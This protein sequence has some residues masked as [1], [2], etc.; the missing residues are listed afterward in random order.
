MIASPWRQR[1][2]VV[3]AVVTAVLLAAAGVAGYVRDELVDRDNFSAR[4]AAALDDAD[5]RAVVADK[6]VDGVAA[7]VTPDVLAIRPLVTTAIASLANTAQFKRIFRRAIADQHR[8]LFYGRSRAV[9]DLEYAGGLLQESLRSVSPLVAR[10]IPPGTEPQ[11]A[12]LDADDLR[13]TIARKLTNVSGWWLPLLIAAALASIAC[14]VLAGGVRDGIAYLGAAIAAAGLTVA[15][16]TMVAAAWVVGRVS[17]GE[18]ERRAAVRAIWDALFADLR[19]SALVAALGGLVIAGVASRRPVVLFAHLRRLSGAPARAPRAL[20]GA[21]LLALGAAVVL[22]PSLAVRAVSVLA[23]LLLILLG[24]GELRGRANK[25]QEREREATPVRPLILV[26]IVAGVVTAMV[27]AVALV[28]PAPKVEAPPALAALAGP[29]GSCNGSL[30]NCGKRLN[31]VVFPST[32]NSYAAADEPGWLFPNQRYGIERQLRDGI[33]GLLIDV[34][35]GELDPATGL[36]RTDLDA[37]GSDRNKV[38]KQLS[39]QALRAAERLVGRIGV[40]TGSGNPRPYLCHTLCELGS[41]PLD[42]QFEI[43]RRFLDANRGE[44]VILFVE[45]YVPVQVIEDSLQRTGLLSEAAEL[46]RDEPLP[47]LGELV[48]ANTRLVVLSELDGGSRPWYLDGFSFVQDTPL[49]ATNPDNLSC[50]RWRGTADSPLLMLNHWTVNFPPSPSRNRAI[51]GPVLRDQMNRCERERGQLPNLVAVDFYELTG[52]LRLAHQR[53][54][55]A[56]TP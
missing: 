34:H 12:A 18:E 15:L 48:D 6:V 11:L 49:T 4:A 7:G 22:E 45:P 54:E 9:L 53:N 52:V 40:G 28:L 8:A 29:A 27:L 36:V 44:V 2:V 13:V 17:A 56:T 43:V 1:I 25:K 33:R 5:V 26:G 46:Q 30:A 38:A 55:R 14:G 50:E 23:G 21:G 42:E 32:H 39:P 51:G 16:L 37:E 47:T 19:T 10:R 35:W 24:I 41:E 3:L 31:E 20:R